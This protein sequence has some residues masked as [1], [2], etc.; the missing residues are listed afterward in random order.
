VYYDWDN[1]GNL[2]ND[3]VN[4]YTYD[5]ANRLK[6]LSNPSAVTSYAYN[7]L[8]DRL[9][10][11]VNGD[12]TTFTMDLNMGLTQALSDGTN[13]YIYGNGRI[14]QVN[15]TTEYFLGDA[16]G[17]VRQL[18]NISG[19]ITYAKAY[20]PY[21]TVTSTTGS[22]QSAYG[23]TNEY[24]SQGLVYLRARQYAPG[25]GR[26]LTR[27]T[28]HGDANNPL[29]L[30]K[31]NYVSGN[32]INATDPTGLCEEIGDEAC[33]GIYEEIIRW[34][35]DLADATISNADGEWIPL[36]KAS[37][38][39]LKFFLE[40]DLWSCL[41]TPETGAVN[42]SFR[43]SCDAIAWVDQHRNEIIS[44]A[45]RHGL[46][47]EL[48]AGVLASEIDF[49]YELTD[50]LVDTELIA[51][52]VM[53]RENVLAAYLLVRPD[54]GPGV[55]SM[56]LSTWEIVQQYYLDCGYDLGATL[57][58]G[59][60]TLSQYQWIM[61]VLSPIGSIES[62]SALARLLADYRTGS[63]GQPKKTTHY[64]DLNFV[65]MAQIF[66][67]YRNGVG[68]LTCWRDDNNDGVRDCGFQDIVDFQDAP[69]L[70]DQAQ[71]AYPYFEFFQRYFEY[72]R[73]KNE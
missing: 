51:Q 60:Q 73:R 37:Y 58:P 17:S 11:T 48:V 66:G 53:G 52:L 71:Q 72:Y 10:E 9:Q 35:P 45:Q 12:T 33:W 21:G 62:A 27:D 7:G 20:D 44:A 19:A 29:S 40:N 36:Y 1:N 8:N 24:A 14:A 41:T 54:P 69:N 43:S 30:N 15:T 38:A 25:M 47:P 56:H 64:N 26:F 3:G 63:G 32:P 57:S 49:D 13:S 42:Y 4:A 2:L 59:G 39:R 46:P 23:Y 18:T 55:A 70:G 6:S 28:W 67:A 5:S 34:R 65:D 68:G 50:M 61:T 16:L 31:W 22:S